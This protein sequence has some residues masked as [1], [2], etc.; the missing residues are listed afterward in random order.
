MN[1]EVKQRQGR[2]ISEYD[3]Q[4][5]IMLNSRTNPLIILIIFVKFVSSLSSLPD[6]LDE[7]V[8]EGKHSVLHLVKIVN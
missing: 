1:S 7:T 3:N 8:I 2:Q 6:K 4:N 5:K